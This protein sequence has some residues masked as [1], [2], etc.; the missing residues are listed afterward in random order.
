MRAR[1]RGGSER[2]RARERKSSLR[3][4]TSEIAERSGQEELLM[5]ENGTSHHSDTPAEV[6]RVLEEVR[7]SCARIRVHYGDTTTGRDW[8][9]VYD[10]TGCVSRSTGPIKVPIL[11]H[12]RRSLGG[13]PMLDHCIVRIRYA[14]RREGGDLYRHPKYHEDKEFKPVA[15]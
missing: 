8:M 6:V 9:D 5:I 1:G 10:V 15:S 7:R 4:T 3:L 14:N 11:L 12:N 13:T 2:A